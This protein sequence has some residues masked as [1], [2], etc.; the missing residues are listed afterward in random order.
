MNKIEI[1]INNIVSD[2]KRAIKING[3]PSHNILETD[4]SSALSDTNSSL[5]Q[6]ENDDASAQKLGI[7][8]FKI[9]NGSGDAFRDNIKKSYNTGQPLHIYIEAP[10]ELTTLPFEL[11]FDDGFLLLNRNIQI[12]RSVLRDR[13]KNKPI[14][15]H[16]RGLRLLFMATSPTDVKPVLSYEKEEELILAAAED[17]SIDMTVEDSGSI[18][19][20]KDTIN[21]APAAYDVV[22]ISGHAGVSTD[23]GPIFVME[24]ETGKKRL[25]NPDELWEAIRNRPPHILFI[26]GCKTGIR[27]SNTESFAHKMVELGVPVV[28][29]WG[30]PVYDAAAIEAAAN[31]YGILSIGNGIDDGVREIRSSIN[32]G[33]FGAF[34]LTDIQKE[35]LKKNW[36]ILRV[37]ADGTPL[38]PVI[39][40]G[41]RKPK[42][43]RGVTYK[44]LANEQVKV[45]V[46][47]FIGRRRNIQRGIA[48][49]KGDVADKYGLL[50]TGT[51][52][53]GKSCL[54]GRLIDRF[55]SRKLVVFHGKFT[56]DDILAK[57]KKLLEEARNRDGLNII[58]SNSEYD[59][60]IKDLLAM[61]FK[62]VPTLFLFDDFEQNLEQDDN[63]TFHIETACR[64]AIKPFLVGIGTAEYNS[65]LIFTSRYSFVFEVEGEDLPDVYL[66]NI[67][68]KSFEG[69]DLTKKMGELE[70]ISDS[71]HSNLYLSYSGGNPRLLEWLNEIAKNENEYVKDNDIAELETILREADDEYI[72][73]Y[74][75]HIIAK[76][77]GYEFHKF[78]Q[79][80]SVFRV[81]E[82]EDAFKSFGG[83][84]YLKK[85][86]R[87][88]LFESDKNEDGRN[89]YWVMPI[90]RESAWGFLDEE[91][92][93]A[94]HIK[95]YN[96]Y[97]DEINKNKN[98]DIK[99]H[100]EALHHALAVENITAAYNH[101]IFVGKHM[102]GLLLYHD[103]K[104]LLQCIADMI[105]D[106]MINE[107]VKNKIG[108]VSKLFSQLGNVYII[109]CKFKKAIYYS[110][111]A[112]RID[113]RI[114]GKNHATVAIEY[115]NIGLAWNNLGK[116]ENAIE[117]YEK[118]LF[119]F[120][121]VHGENHHS[122]SSTYNNIGLVWDMLGEPRKAINEY[123]EKAL[124]I[125]LIIYGENHHSVANR[126]N[127]IGTAWY[128]LGELRKAIEYFEKALIIFLNDH[129]KNHP[130]VAVTYNNIGS[131]WFQH[132][133]YRKAI[134]YF[135][136]VLSID[137][138]IYGEDHPDVAIDYNNIGKTS[139]ALGETAT[140]IEYYK[141]ALTIAL[142]FYDIDHPTV[143]IFQRNLDL[144]DCLTNC[145]NPKKAKGGEAVWYECVSP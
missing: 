139:E 81:A 68:L 110:E 38:K 10:F 131:A 88:T 104:K 59:D 29:A 24:S 19:G 8:L 5:N 113:E 89:T 3:L 79:H 145:V 116:K 23:N 109:L 96:W 62:V 111:K 105:T 27:G 125:D 84:E 135:K 140:A 106:M 93:K 33:A 102:D 21:H 11:L 92:Q 45:L 57:L 2:G 138:N 52:G 7:N 44:T 127:N 61:V 78:L 120:L 1:S 16:Q 133:E 55:K 26:S 126:Y 112:L 86:V 37:F 40:A 134:E 15:S 137:I 77:Q 72:Q 69:A 36:R 65:S 90:I 76:T 129:G 108:V 41:L 117:C 107:D 124:S 87:L 30:L 14:I 121:N 60:R 98:I 42:A 128:T 67:S 58:Q 35:R 4:I 99:Y 25:V 123:Y 97:N 54:A 12:I 143:K 119:I 74:L 17:H 103:E 18:E 95:A 100:K 66:E 82:I 13:N 48:V 75:A 70:A 39:A 118:A 144:G 9:L 83:V 53:L 47:G 63:G 94:A 46:T 56:A 73:K 51:A 142:A 20:L 80:A 141:N 43:Q 49:L 101:A 122:V 114:F 22:H 115:N 31:F 28:M 130:H 6:W 91:E 85:G 71:K 136:E 64:T 32:K 132:G 50:I 34:K